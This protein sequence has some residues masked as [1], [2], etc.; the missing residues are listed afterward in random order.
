MA[1]PRSAFRAICPVGLT[2]GKPQPAAWE[3]ID[4]QENAPGRF[5]TRLR[6]AGSRVMITFGEPSRI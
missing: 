6:G 5:L 2:I 3:G 4:F 1:A